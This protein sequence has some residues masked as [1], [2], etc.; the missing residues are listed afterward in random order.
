[1]VELMQDLKGMGENNAAWRRKTLLHRDTI[2]AAS[3][4][5][6]GIFKLKFLRPSVCNCHSHH[7]HVSL[8]L[9]VHR[10]NK[11]SWDLSCVFVFCIYSLSPVISYSKLALRSGLFDKHHAIMQNDIL[12]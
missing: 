6:Q 2:L 5:Y 7:H 8:L 10:S 12:A 4:I 9:T 11:T 3:S 1:M